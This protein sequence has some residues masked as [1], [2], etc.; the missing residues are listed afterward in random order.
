ML[1]EIEC[2]MNKSL[3]ENAIYYLVAVAA[4]A[5]LLTRLWFGPGFVFLCQSLFSLI[6]ICMV[7]ITY[8]I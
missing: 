7:Y 4:V 8:E 1:A 2:V 5:L 3:P 6:F